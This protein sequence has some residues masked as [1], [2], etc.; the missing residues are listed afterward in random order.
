MK[1]KELYERNFSTDENGK[2]IDDC[3]N[4]YRNENGEVEFLTDY[5]LTEI[6][7]IYNGN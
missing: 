5:N 7:V 4:E 3:G 2:V 6:E 1:Y